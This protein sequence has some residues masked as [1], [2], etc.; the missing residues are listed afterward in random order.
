M[1]SVDIA[2]VLAS[3]SYNREDFSPLEAE[4]GV[5]LREVRFPTQLG[6]PQVIILPG[7]PDAAAD[8]D[9]LTACGMADAILEHARCG[10]WVV[11]ICGGMHMMAKRL[12]DPQHVKYPFAEKQMLGLMALDVHYGGEQIF[13]RLRHVSAPGG[14]E[15]RGFETHRGQCDGAE[16][17][18]FRREDGSPIGYG[19]GRCWGTYLHRLFDS[20]VFR[21]HF[22]SAVRAECADF[23][24][25]LPN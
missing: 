3:A 8:F 11:G 6:Q 9:V 22:L 24:T 15:L 12:Y 7:T 4:P 14:L 25:F 5:T 23:G 20:V 2:L 10:G 18:L 17:V 19:H 21:Q 16:P 13:R 1:I